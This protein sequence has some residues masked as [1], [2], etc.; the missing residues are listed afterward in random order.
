MFDARPCLTLEERVD[1]ANRTILLPVGEIDIRVH[2]SL[3]AHGARLWTSEVSTEASSSETSKLPFRLA[4]RVES[5]ET[6]VCLF[7]QLVAEAFAGSVNCTARS[8]ETCGACTILNVPDPRHGV[9]EM[10]SNRL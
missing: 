3:I 1:D 5:A 7:K 6:K 8:P 9:S 4:R 10:G 2:E